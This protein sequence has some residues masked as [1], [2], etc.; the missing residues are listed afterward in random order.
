MFVRAERTQKKL[1]ILISGPTNSGKT[2]S[3]LRIAKGLGPRIALY[4]TEGR[5]S[6]LY[7][8]DFDFDVALAETKDPRE[9][10]KAIVEAAKGG[11][12]AI[13]VDSGSHLWERTRGIVDE[14]TRSMKNPNSYVAWAKGDE[15]WNPFIAMIQNPPIHIIVTSRSKTKYIQD[16]A[17]GKKSV[18]KIG[19]EPQLRE[20]T[21]Y[22]F[23]IWF[24]LN[25]LHIASVGKT[26]YSK[27]DGM[28]FEPL[29]ED[30]GKMLAEW[31][32]T[33]KEKKTTSTE[34]HPIMKAT[35]AATA[36]G[37]D[38]ATIGIILDK[39]KERW[40]DADDDHV[41]EL[42]QAIRNARAVKDAKG[43]GITDEEITSAL[44]SDAWLFAS[45]EG[46]ERLVA[47]TRKA[48]SGN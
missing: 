13:I 3:A 36:S 41:R 31:A 9:A 38:D 15:A 1:S 30:T 32:S 10:C 33:G 28:F 39:P 35:K 44:G 8:D 46:M 4:D 48:R 7:A 2:Y 22:E 34:E 23:D 45:V 12:D 25:E 37:I 21:D 14:A 43:S 20:N 18:R 29:T 11:Y 42:C 27:I 16:E 26:R 24:D 19:T 5:A 17:N 40:H 47:E 6:S